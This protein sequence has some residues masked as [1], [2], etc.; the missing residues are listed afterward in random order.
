MNTN[1]HEGPKGLQPIGTGMDF[2]GPDSCPFVSIRGL[3]K[4]SRFCFGVLISNFGFKT[5]DP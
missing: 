4:Y 5:Y 3:E 2:S 1:K